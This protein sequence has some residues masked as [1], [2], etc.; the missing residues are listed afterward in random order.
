M[1]QTIVCQG[2]L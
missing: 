1:I 2:R